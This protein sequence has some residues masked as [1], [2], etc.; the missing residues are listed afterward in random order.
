[1]GRTTPSAQ[2][3]GPPPA[4]RATSPQI[5][6]TIPSISSPPAP[7]APA[8]PPPHFVG[9]TSEPPVPPAPPAPLA[10]PPHFVGR[11]SV[12]FRSGRLGIL[13]GG[14]CGT[15]AA[16]AGLRRSRSSEPGRA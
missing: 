5:G 3:F 12:P 1:M 13:G 8:A 7:P 14:P 9:R 16:T 6:G 10:P 11:T 15:R 2:T 4:L